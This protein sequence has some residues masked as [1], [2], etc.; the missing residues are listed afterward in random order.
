MYSLGSII[1]TQWG[2]RRLTFFLRDYLSRIVAETQVGPFRQRSHTQR[3][4]RNEPSQQHADAPRRLPDLA[5]HGGSGVPSAVPF[6]PSGAQTPSSTFPVEY[7]S[8]VYPPP[9]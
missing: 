3:L 6:L 2:F 1:V 8:L 4:G 7:T 9:V 5:D